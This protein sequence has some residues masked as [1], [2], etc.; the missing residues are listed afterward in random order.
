M[1]PRLSH[2]VITL[3]LLV[4]SSYLLWFYLE[5]Y[6]VRA[7]A[8][9]IPLLFAVQVL[10]SDSVEY[11]V[12]KRMKFGA[13]WFSVFMAPGTILHEL[14]HFIVA[15]F[16]GCYITGISLFKPNPTTGMLGY[17]KYRTPLDKWLV[18][19]E[20]TIAFAPFFGCGSLMLLIN[21]AHG[22]DIL[23]LVDSVRVSVPEHFLAAFIHMTVNLIYS[24]LDMDYSL[25]Y[26]WILLYLQFCFAIGA[27]PSSHD[28]KGSFRNLYHHPISTLFTILFL[29]LMLFLSE[30]PYDLGGIETYISEGIQFLLKF[31][32]TVLLASSTLL[33]IMLPTAFAF[34]K[35]AE[36]RGSFK[37]IPVILAPTVF[38]A[39]EDYLGFGSTESMAAALIA[40]TVSY[41]VLRYPKAFIKK[42]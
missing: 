22:G 30:E 2:R 31:T 25:I 21:Y 33:F 15:L 23:S 39:M 20:F 37:F 1:I 26:S 28:F 29:W 42:K 19:R 14:T 6:A 18:L 35:L 16:T 17:V 36:I 41:I 27:A 34:S 9:F 8:S 4:S 13:Y 32:I 24:F 5:G 12:T 3:I 40:F 7:Y 11:Y 10:L 38:T